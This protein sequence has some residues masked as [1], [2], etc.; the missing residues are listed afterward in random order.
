MADDEDA[1]QEKF[2]ALVEKSSAKEA[3]N[4]L[5]ANEDLAVSDVQGWKLLNSI[6]LELSEK[7]ETEQQIL[8]SLAYSSLRKKKLL[9]AFGCVEPSPLSLPYASKDIDVPTLESTISLPLKALT[10]RGT[11]FAWQIAG[12]VLCTIEY[13]IASGLGIDPLKTVIPLTAAAFV[14]DRLALS[15]AVFESAYRLLFPVYKEKVIKHEAGHFLLAYLLGCPIQGF[16]LSAWDATRAGIRGQAGTVFFDNDLSTQ[17][18]ANKVTRTAIDRYTIVL[19]GGIA[20]EA[21][22]FEQ[23]EGGASD[24]SALVN[25]LIGLTPAWSQERV[26]NQARW[27]VT[28]AV[29]LLREHRD[30]FTALTEAMAANKPLGECVEAIEGALGGLDPL[31]AVARAEERRRDGTFDTP[32]TSLQT[33]GPPPS[34]LLEDIEKQ[35]AEKRAKLDEI[36]TQEEDLKAQMRSLDEESVASDPEAKVVW[37]KAETQRFMDTL[38]KASRKRKAAE[39]S[40]KSK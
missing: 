26:L 11:Q 18:N 39:K 22:S 34:L 29:L 9:R 15:G 5:R 19:M 38:L 3:I 2:N 7:T 25:F 21:I 33:E 4:L 13:Q 17:L 28:E 20:A 40:G 32:T 14:V 27:A 35:I 23:A 12:L 30:A 16:F 10:P 36:K 6:P 8:T 1:T 37:D 31:P 24:E